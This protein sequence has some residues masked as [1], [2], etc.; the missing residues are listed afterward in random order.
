MGMFSYTL[1]TSK[2]MRYWA[3]QIDAMKI[4]PTD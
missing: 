3:E 4:L 1:D 2:T